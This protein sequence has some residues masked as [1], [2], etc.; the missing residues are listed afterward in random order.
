MTECIT[1]EVFVVWRGRRRRRIGSGGGGIIGEVRIALEFC[2]IGG[3]TGK[4]KSYQSIVE[5]E[6]YSG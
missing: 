4:S 5:G 6:S 1:T 2:S 3:Q